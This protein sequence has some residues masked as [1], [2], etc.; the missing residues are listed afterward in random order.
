MPRSGRVFSR[1]FK[2][3]VIRRLFLGGLLPSRARFRFAGAYPYLIIARRRH[4]APVPV[5]NFRVSFEGC[6]SQG[7]YREFAYFACWEQPNGAEY[8]KD[9]NALKENS[10]CPRTG[11]FRVSSGN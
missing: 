3:S 11:K 7:K 5:P 1:E 6:S 2:L 9:N 8:R 10:R 4:P